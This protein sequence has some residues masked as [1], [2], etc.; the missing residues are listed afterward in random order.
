MFIL[1][2]YLSALP[3]ELRS[4][5]P[6]DT[7]FE[8][9]NVATSLPIP[10]PAPAITATRPNKPLILQLDRLTGYLYM[11]YSYYT[12]FFKEIYTNKP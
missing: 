5:K 11:L 2:I 9:N 6:T 1:D 8:A 7:P 12:Y 4:T 3:S 10:L